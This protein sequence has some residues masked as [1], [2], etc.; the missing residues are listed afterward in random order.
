MT[1]R[2]E[3]QYGI[4]QF[5]DCYFRFNYEADCFEVYRIRSIYCNTIVIAMFPKES[6]VG[7]IYYYEENKE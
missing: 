4:K 3:L 7:G 1:V 6:V 2:V 5:K